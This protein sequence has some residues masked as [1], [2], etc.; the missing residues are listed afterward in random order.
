MVDRLIRLCESANT[1]THEELLHTFFVL[2]QEY[3]DTLSFCAEQ[4]RIYQEMTLQY[5][6]MK[7][8]LEGTKRDLASKIKLIEKLNDQLH[9]SKNDQFGRRSEKMGDAVVSA[10]NGN[11]Q[12]Q[13]PVAEDAREPEESSELIPVISGTGLFGSG[14]KKKSGGKGKTSGN[15]KR[16][17][18]KRNKD[19]EG[20]PTVK[21]FVYDA[22]ELERLYGFGWYIREW[23]VTRSYETVKVPV[24]V[25]E[26]YRP[27]LAVGADQMVVRIPNGNPLLR[28]SLV[29]A[30]IASS[31]MYNLTCLGLPFYRQSQD[32]ARDGIDISRQTMSYWSINLSMVYLY[33]VYEMLCCQVRTYSYNQVDETH[34]TVI[35]DGRRAGSVSY[36]WT[37][38]TSE[39]LDVPPVVV[40]CYELTRGTDHLRNF[41][42]NQFK[43]NITSDGYVAY[44]VFESE[45]DGDVTVSGC[46][47]HCRRYFWYA[48]LI[49]NVTGL[50]MEQIENLPEYRALSL[51]G[52]IYQ[53]E[54]PLKEVTARE[55]AEARDK[56]VRKKVEAFFRF[57]DSLDIQ[58]PAY[59]AKL[60]QAITYARNQKER[61]VKFLDD[62]N[63]P[64]DNLNVERKI[65]P[66]STVRRNSLF[67]YSTSGAEAFTIIMSLVET[68]KANEAHPYYYLKYLLEVMP[69]YVSRPRPGTV[70][71]RLFPWS[72]E[73]RTYEEKEIRRAIR[74]CSADT[75]AVRPTTSEIKA[76]LR[77]KGISA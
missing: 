3:S 12:A 5:G 24:F 45:S 34:W 63:I 64:L 33:P 6:Q 53:E 23:S 22:E 52:E 72:E 36:I 15:G 46:L 59:S 54:E 41:Y 65:R 13:D 2:A 25:K 29:S 40:Y 16:S 21:D 62:P 11:S 19:L 44:P 50:N 39:L 77:Q 17:S 69:E 1:M 14:G 32:L 10:M 43:G 51:I 68:A 61:L 27:V 55:R 8:E 26:T 31:I 9:M 71:K 66:V 76:Q 35:N 42:G 18:G 48:L 58:N 4:E 60:V 49:Q 73:Y 47:A 67:S 37:H 30:S 7:D 56:S 70:E 57:I 28:G 38:T 20:L 75:T 74:L